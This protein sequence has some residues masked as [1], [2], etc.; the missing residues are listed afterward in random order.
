MMRSTEEM[1]TRR[2]SMSTIAK[3][4]N[5]ADGGAIIT[6]S[7]SKMRKEAAETSEADTDRMNANGMRAGGARRAD[8]TGDATCAPRMG[9]VRSLRSEFLRLRTSA[10]VSLHAACALAGGLLCGAY[11]SVAAWDARF[12]ADAYVQLLGALMPLMAGIVCGLAVDAEDEAGGMANLLAV[13]SRHLAVTAKAAAL[14][15][16]GAAALAVAVA[17]FAGVLAATGRAALDPATLACSVAGLAAGSA[18][19][20]LVSLALSFRFGR[21]AAI[22]MGAAGLLLAF[23]SL[24]GLA[25]GLMTGEL[26]AASGNILGLV[27]FSWAARL[28][29]LA[30]ESWLGAGTA[31]AGQVA[32][33]VTLTSSLTAL[34][35]VTLAGGLLAWFGRF[36]P[37]RREG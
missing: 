10:L 19:L 17:T 1:N 23:F 11:F 22:G 32:E 18:P 34:L 37:H 5:A 16:M 2:A 12:G 15:L 8:R 3:S 14:W 31:A 21:N 25:H 9:F 24:G 29:S 6:G 20:Y 28:G 13:P 33:Q 30:I 4:V 36:E 26:T 7:T 35:T 27:P